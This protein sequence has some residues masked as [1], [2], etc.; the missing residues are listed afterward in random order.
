ML[1]SG[2]GGKSAFTQLPVSAYRCLECS[3]SNTLV[4]ERFGKEQGGSWVCATSR[5]CD[6]LHTALDLQTLDPEIGQGVH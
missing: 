5:R 6:G 1:A 2:G 4:L 3:Q